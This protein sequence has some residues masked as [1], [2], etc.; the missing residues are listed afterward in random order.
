MYGCG[1]I[2]GQTRTPHAVA[3]TAD[4][5]VLFSSGMWRDR[6]VPMN[7]HGIRFCCPACRAPVHAVGVAYQ[8]DG[9]RRSYPV[10]HGIA[11]FRLR[12]DRYL[13]LE[14]E[15]EKAARLAAEA[16][17]RSF[18]QLLDYYYQI[19]DDVSSELARRYKAGVLAAPRHLRALSTDVKRAV[20]EKPGSAVLDA[21]CGAGGMLIALSNAG[22]PV[23]GLDIA[24]RWLVICRKRLDELGIEAQLVCADLENPPFAPGTFDAITAI[25]IVEHVRDVATALE[26]IGTLLKPYGQTWVTASNARTLGPHPTTRIWGVGWLPPALRTW[27]VRKLRGVDALRFTHLLTARQLARLATQSGLRVRSA[28]PRR[29]DVPDSNYPRRERWLMRLYAAL[30]RLTITRRLLLAIGPSFELVLYRD[31]AHGAALRAVG[32]GEAARP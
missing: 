17:H 9:C 4:S 30:V 28:G 21:G 27:L 7:R 25:D 10:L 6:D 11:D 29:I 16:G 12:P 31:P 5:A 3:I 1:A 24:L 18:E 26:S 15:R 23:I 20:Q 19:T 8:C 22:V 2:D 32:C 14:Q 13:S